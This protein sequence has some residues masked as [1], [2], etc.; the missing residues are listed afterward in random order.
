M[1]GN[2]GKLART[3]RG[4][5][6]HV[7]R[8]VVFC[9][10]GFACVQTLSASGAC[11][12][13]DDD[14]HSSDIVVTARAGHIG[15][16]ADDR[17]K[18]TPDASTLRSTTPHLDTPQIVNVV[19]AQ[20]IRDQ[21][22]RYLDDVLANVSGVTQSNTLASTQDTILKRGFGGNRDGSVM[23]NGMPL[24]QGRGFNAAAES[25]EV[26]KGPSSLLY[27]IM[28]PGGVINIVSKKPLLE[29]HLN[30]ALTGSGYANDKYGME[31][32]ADVTGRILGNLAARLV[33]DHDDEDYW[34]NFGQRRETLIAPSLAW[35]GQTT[36]VVAWYEYRKYLYPFDRGTVLDPRTMRPL[37]IPYT[38][39]LD[40]Y[41]NKMFG[42]SHLAQLSVDHHLAGGWA[43][44]LSASYNSD[45]YDAGQLRVSSVNT[46][47][48]T[49]G[50]SD[51]GTRGAL[52][53]DVYAT[54]Y[55]DGRVDTLG[56]RNDVQFG[57]EL[58]HRKIY[59]RD[60]LRQKV[61][62]TFSYLNPV[63][64]IEPFSS[65]VSPSESDQTDHL[66]NYSVFAQDS[67]H[68]GDRWI[69]VLGGRVLHYTQVA[70][71]G[72]PFVANTDIEGTYVLPRAGLVYKPLSFLSLYVSYTKSLKPASTIAP[73]SSGVVLNS[74]FAPEQGRSF[75]G[76]IKIDLPRRITATLAVYDIDKRNVLVSQF[77][78]VTKL[79]DYR[80][81][82][83]ARSRGV[84]VDV[85]GQL[86]NRLS[87]IGSYALTAAKTTEDPVFAG[88][89]L[90]NVA[91]DT[92]SLS[93]AYDLGQIAGGDRFR[94]GG[95]P[96]YV[97]RR[98]GDS[99]NSFFLESYVTMDA[100]ANYDMIVAGK[101]VGL[102]LNVKNLFDKQYY[103]SAVNQ[104]G[105]SVG[106]PRRVLL[107]LSFAL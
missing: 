3:F 91:R 9:G 11:A 22:P 29:T 82:G 48:G 53:T 24:V 25:V 106:D 75:E 59:R 105:V 83:R 64:G 10:V 41:N 7:I 5:I 23:H 38:E 46:T 73:L 50:R 104:Y 66:H 12:Q 34:R 33:V 63:Y 94:V 14:H 21:R 98:A 30:V 52:S 37:A 43:A 77:N 39:R 88:K 8:Y 102:Q 68:L 15:K 87:A 54:A 57:V 13:T 42:E 49:L 1:I 103:S 51:D 74:G 72:R 31:G 27:G 81:S 32:M 20:V 16:G 96:H 70:G 40:D 36:Q 89:L 107:T 95:G 67:I 17:Y 78:D 4:I 84:E 76:A 65:T 100:F 47:T 60:L 18:P 97:G 61:Q 93:L 69:V 85:A 6:L 90:A 56:L 28:D 71:K 58:E 45:A 92:A 55:A 101:K 35:Y 26:L 99:A 79:T 86:T 44:H 2:S 19:S 80:T 62:S